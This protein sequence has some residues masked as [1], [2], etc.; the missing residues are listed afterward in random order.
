MRARCWSAPAPPAL[1][2]VV[3]GGE[4]LDLAALRPW[5]A[6]H[7]DRQPELVNMYG[8]TETTVHVTCPAASAPPTSARTA[9]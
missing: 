5:V 9:A 7:G 2:Y 4:A 1:R 3:F 8:I 6:R